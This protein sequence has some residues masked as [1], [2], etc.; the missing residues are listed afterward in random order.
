MSTLYFAYGSNLV[1]ERLRKRVGPVQV[2]GVAHLRGFR[3]SLDK[4]GKDGSGKAN[5][6]ADAAHDVWGVLYELDAQ[7][8]TRLDASEPGYDRIAVQ[9]ACGDA[10]HAAQTYQSQR[11][12]ED[13]VAF[14]WYKRL[15]VDGAR[16][17]GLPDAWLRDLEALPE[18]VDPRRA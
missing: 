15:I 6:H 16:A 12:T 11:L 17:H 4:R 8:W 9:V 7:A 5:L 18:R 2:I 10:L 3:L 13:P 1:L 14:A